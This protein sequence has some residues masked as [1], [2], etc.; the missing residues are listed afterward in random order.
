MLDTE[1]SPSASSIQAIEKPVQIRTDDGKYLSGILTVPR[2]SVCAT[3]LIL[4]GSGPVGADGDVSGPFLG[5]GHGGKPA[6]LSRQIAERLAELGISSLRWNKRG[7]GEPSAPMPTLQQLIGDCRSALALLQTALPGQKLLLC[8]F[9]EGALVSL[10]LANDFPIDALFLLGLP[11]RPYPEI[12][13]YQF[14]HWPLRKLSSL[15]KDGGDY[16]KREDLAQYEITQLPLLSVDCDTLAW[17]VS[18]KIPIESGLRPLYETYFDAIQN[19]LASEA[20][21]PWFDSM[22]ALPPVMDLAYGLSRK[23]PQAPVFIYSGDLDPQLDPD[24]IRE[25]WVHF[26]KLAE[27]K[28]FPGL[29]H[30]FAPMD[31]SIGQIKT[32]G[33][34]SDDLLETL[35]CDAGSVLSFLRSTGNGSP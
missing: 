1:N 15:D 32:S 14:L 19:L 9:S 7:F 5:A 33:P 18:G 17:D 22:L 21:K 8:G 2:T 30:C 20:M 4:S 16:L 12:L 35:S 24:W 11:S 31:G 27:L 10:L 25:D 6:P 13:A 3:A 28:T 29:G 23:N 26:G 34:L